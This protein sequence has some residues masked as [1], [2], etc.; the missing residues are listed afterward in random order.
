MSEQQAVSCLKP[1]VNCTCP[2]TECDNHSQCCKCVTAHRNKG[3]LTNCMAELA[4]K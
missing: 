3:S 4:K 2:K 1:D